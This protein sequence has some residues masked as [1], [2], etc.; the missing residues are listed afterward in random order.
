MSQ[1]PDP[2]SS[3]R[4]RLWL[5]GST[6]ALLTIVILIGVFSQRY[7]GVVPPTLPPPISQGYSADDAL[8]Q[9]QEAN[10]RADVA[11]DSIDKIL[12]IIQVMG[13]VVA[14]ATAVIALAG[15]RT[16]RDLN[17]EMDSLHKLE[18]DIENALDEVRDVRRLLSQVESAQ[19]TTDRLRSE[20]GVNLA[21][22]RGL[23]DELSANMRSLDEHIS[24]VY[25]AGG[26]SQLGQRQIG[27]GNLG[28]AAKVFQ[29]V[30]DLDPTN[31]IYQY[32]LGDLLMR[33]GRV[34]QGINH[35]RTARQDNYKYPSADASYAYALR[36]R[37]DQEENA[38]QRERLYYE[39]GEIFLGVYEVDPELVDISG[40][41]VFGALAG[42]FRRQRR[43]DDALHWYEHCRR[44]TPHNSYPINNLAVLNFF[45][46]N[47]EE[48]RRYFKQVVVIAKEK[49]TARSSDYWARFDLITA[50]VAMGESFETLADDLE[51]LEDVAANPLEKFLY[52]LQELKTANHPPAGV[53]EVIDQIVDKVKT[54]IAD[55]ENHVN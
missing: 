52:G 40:E 17:E 47:H 39:S 20:V 12:G 9:A 32:F 11:L 50:R 23:R 8:I 26:L 43:Y 51:K 4:P 44:V 45:Q 19:Q 24:N 54:I 18:N 35:L 27:L 16:S 48:A 3:P 49:L 37:G 30:C 22:L 36:L 33:L 15:Y 2:L 53:V 14:I 38:V 7:S 25:K 29:D 42:L 28:A 34:E 41:S 1:R 55:R 5:W 6:A 21:D 13:V 10:I 46:G 31:P